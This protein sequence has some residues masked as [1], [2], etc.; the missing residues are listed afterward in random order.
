VFIII[1]TRVTLKPGDVLNELIC[2]YFIKNIANLMKI[3]IVYCSNS[4]K[5]HKGGATG[6]HIT[7]SWRHVRTV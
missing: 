1:Q 3:G 6:A 2:H 5:I 7:Y 4:N